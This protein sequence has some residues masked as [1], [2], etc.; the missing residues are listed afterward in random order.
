MPGLR[1]F[2]FGLLLT[3][4]ACGCGAP[5]E[6][7]VWKPNASDLYTIRFPE[8]PRSTKQHTLS[9]SLGDLLVETRRIE[10]AGVVYSVTETYYPQVAHELE[11]ATLFQGVIDGMRGRDAEL[12]ADRPLLDGQVQGR[13]IHIDAGKN[14]IR[15]KLFFH[16]GFLVQVLAI[17]PR[18]K[19][20]ETEPS[21]F[22]DSIH[23]IE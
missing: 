19:V 22:L 7:V 20:N 23:W 16:R 6:P 11:L 2:I 10:K 4:L 1:T 8:E 12:K 13:Y 14:E 17:G 15:G 18:A 3:S 5:S 9:T 21:Q